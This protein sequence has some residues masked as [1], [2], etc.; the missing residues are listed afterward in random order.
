MNADPHPPLVRVGDILHL[1][2]SDWAGR[3]R[4]RLRVSH[5]QYGNDRYAADRV[6]VLGTV[7][8]VEQDDRMLLITVHM[9]ALRRPGV[10]ERTNRTNKE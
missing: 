2:A 7:L 6:V 4:L 1:R 5:V 10:V 8:T 3:H 9:S